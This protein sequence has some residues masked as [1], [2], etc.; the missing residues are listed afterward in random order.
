MIDKVLIDRD[1]LGAT[2]VVAGLRSHGIA[3]VR[4]NGFAKNL[5]ADR[6]CQLE[7]VKGKTPT[8]ATRDTRVNRSLFVA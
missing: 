6:G 4:S 8:Y 5:L 3:A 7:R 2:G 1:H